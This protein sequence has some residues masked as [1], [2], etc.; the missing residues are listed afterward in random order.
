[1]ADVSGALALELRLWSSGCRPCEKNEID[2]V[3]VKVSMPRPA[4]PGKKGCLQHAHS[5]PLLSVG[6]AK[7]KSGSNLGI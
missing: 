3:V 7:A 6:L 5:A 1:M 2:L 4:F